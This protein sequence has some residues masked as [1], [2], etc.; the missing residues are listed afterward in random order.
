MGENASKKDA[1]ANKLL[2]RSEDKE[3]KRPIKDEWL[4]KKNLGL[5]I[6]DTTRDCLK[7][8][9]IKFLNT[10][11]TT[12][13]HS[14]GKELKSEHHN[15]YQHSIHLFYIMKFFLEL[16]QLLS[17]KD[18]NTFSVKNWLD[19][20]NYKIFRLLFNKIKY[21]KD[22][23]LWLELQIGLECLK[24]MSKTIEMMGSKNSDY[25]HETRNKAQQLQYRILCEKESLELIVDVVKKSSKQSVSF[26]RSLI[27]TVHRFLSMLE[28]VKLRKYIYVKQKYQPNKPSKNVKYI[29]DEYEYLMDKMDSREQR[30]RTEAFDRYEKCYV[31]EEV[32]STYCALL[33]K[34]Y[35]TID[36]D[37]H[38][39]NSMFFRIFSHCESSIFLKL[40][41]MELL[42]RVLEHFK[43]L[44]DSFH[45][46][47]NDSQIKFKEFAYKIVEDFAIRMEKNPLTY[48]E[49]IFPKIDLFTEHE[50]CH[51]ALLPEE[52]GHL[53][54][55]KQEELPHE[56][57]VE[58]WI[59]N[60]LSLLLEENKSYLI[61]W[62]QEVLRKFAEESQDI[63]NG[64]ENVATKSCD[65][66]KN[67]VII[68]DNAEQWDAL[69]NDEH[70]MA[71]LNLLKFKKIT[72]ENG[73]R[74]IITESVSSTD[75]L[76]LVDK[77]DM[78]LKIIDLKKEME[79]KK[80]KE[81]ELKKRKREKE[82]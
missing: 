17:T 20:M 37:F 33:D 41:F 71:L 50:S 78:K 55:K 47:L 29:K 9:A 1:R 68:A 56:I 31:N 67:H 12:L 65:S 81:R 61:E 80:E 74:W 54:F 18:L 4:P 32:L 30:H 63:E 43:E 27:E 59:E 58:Q 48:I 25:D 16:C 21:F 34:E 26:L 7:V 57:Q 38:Y 6:N 40:S 28:R 75:L 82:E 10:I 39:I 73:V 64:E 19:I 35:E 44:T 5:D 14:I 42:H 13:V 23:K 46:N 77:I 45:L 66:S 15:K 22:K 49:L 36:L 24:Q 8:T 53:G 3:N 51:Q 76:T 69:A 79:E 70:F 11:F 2:D 62:L 72:D 60:L 52:L